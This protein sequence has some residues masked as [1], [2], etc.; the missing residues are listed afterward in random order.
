MNRSWSTHLYG[1]LQC[2]PLAQHLECLRPSCP[3]PFPH[4]DLACRPS[5]PP[6]LQRARSLCSGRFLLW[7][8]LLGLNLL[9]AEKLLQAEVIVVQKQWESG[10]KLRRASRLYHAVGRCYTLPQ[11][12]EELD[13]ENPGEE[14][15]FDWVSH[16]ASGRPTR[17][18]LR[19]DVGPV[20]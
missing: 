20:C 17:R 8:A 13:W 15:N 11:G 5:H 10:T 19:Q 12:W 2:H 18:L 16:R 7:V 9:T 1:I 3:Y 6:V 4:S 14:R